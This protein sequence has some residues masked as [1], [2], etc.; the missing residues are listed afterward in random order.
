MKV[1]MTVSKRGNQGGETQLR[2]DYT[3]LGVNRQCRRFLRT[4]C[5]VAALGPLFGSVSVLAESDKVETVVEGFNIYAPAFIFEDN[6]EGLY[7]GGWLSEADKPHDKIYRC[8]ISGDGNCGQSRVVLSR[9]ELP[10][11]AQHV[12]DPT[13]VRLNGH[14]LMAFTV[15]RGSC[16]SQADNEIWLARSND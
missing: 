11:P 1:S 12:N 6:F 14:V 5:V 9:A 8:I 15:C 4:W 10:V 13:L 3:T 2:C 7:F 16:S